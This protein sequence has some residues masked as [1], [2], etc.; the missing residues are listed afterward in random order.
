[1]DSLVVQRYSALKEGGAVGP[2]LDA[3]TFEV[4][5]QSPQRRRVRVRGIIPR[6]LVQPDGNAIDAS[7]GSECGK[8]KAEQFSRVED[9]SPSGVEIQLHDLKLRATGRP[10]I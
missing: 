6:S 7:A 9:L 8:R 5:R 2:E 3:C 1:M 10:S 4:V